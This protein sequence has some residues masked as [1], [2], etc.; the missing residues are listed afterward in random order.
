MSPSDDLL[1][2]DFYLLAFKLIHIRCV[3]FTTPWLAQF[4]LVT[5]EFFF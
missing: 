3:Q 2:K 5:F 4:S 1:L